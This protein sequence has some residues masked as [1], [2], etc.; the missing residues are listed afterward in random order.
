MSILGRLQYK[1]PQTAGPLYVR[2][3]SDACPVYAD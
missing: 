2:L 1:Q 3:F